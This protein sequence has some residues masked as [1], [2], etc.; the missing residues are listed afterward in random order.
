MQS[1]NLKNAQQREPRNDAS[2]IHAIP[3]APV[4][5]E[6]ENDGEFEPKDDALGIA[7]YNTKQDSNQG[8]ENFTHG[9]SP[10]NGSLS[11]INSGVQSTD[12]NNNKTEEEL[13]PT[14]TDEDVGTECRYPSH[15]R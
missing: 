3:L 11:H 4:R 1:F 10:T 12:V 2:S 5:P 15:E 7:E 8:I 6:I 14:S 9:G 13:K